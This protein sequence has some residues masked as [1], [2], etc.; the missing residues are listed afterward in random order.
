MPKKKKGSKKGGSSKKKKKSR[1]GLASALR[2]PCPD[3]TPSIHPRNRSAS[4]AK[5]AGSKVATAEELLWQKRFRVSEQSRVSA[6][7]PR[8]IAPSPH[9]RP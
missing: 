7:A 1:C 9:A 2:A 6:P 4:G 3:N 5:A 8:G